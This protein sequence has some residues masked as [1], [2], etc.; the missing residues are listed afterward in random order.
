MHF[1]Q[2]WSR[3]ALIQLRVHTRRLAGQA[4]GQQKS[5]VLKSHAWCS[6][7]IHQSNTYWSLFSTV[8]V[9]VSARFILKIGRL[10]SHISNITANCEIKWID[11]NAFKSCTP[12]HLSIVVSYHICSSRWD[13][14]KF[15]ERWVQRLHHQLKWRHQC[16]GNDLYAHLCWP[17]LD[18][19]CSVILACKDVS[20]VFK[21]LLLA[22]IFQYT[23]LPLKTLTFSIQCRSGC[24]LSILCLKPRW[25]IC[26]GVRTDVHC[27]GY[28]SPRMHRYTRTTQRPII[29]VRTTY[30]STFI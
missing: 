9:R 12:T 10:F 1:D 20:L 29:S 17:G 4:V 26:G 25:F 3:C 22:V 8:F 16:I 24:C 13:F 18:L 30:Y 5:N 11:Y 15:C 2:A 28:D 7:R 27:S 19:D 14:S 23:M 6:R 21:Q